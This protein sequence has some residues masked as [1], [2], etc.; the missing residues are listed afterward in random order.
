MT[1]RNLPLDYHTQPLVRSWT[2]EDEDTGAFSRVE[3]RGTPGRYLRARFP[4]PG[5]LTHSGTRTR[6]GLPRCF[7]SGQNQE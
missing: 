1:H 3:L 7:A 6:G 5:Q 2:E 4:L